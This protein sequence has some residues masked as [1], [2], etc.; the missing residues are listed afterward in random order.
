MKNVIHVHPWLI[1]VNVWQN[2]Y[3]IIKQNKLEIKIFLKCIQITNR[4]LTKEENL[5]IRKIFLMF[6]FTSTE[7]IDI[8]TR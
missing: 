6:T 2:Q 3:S 4:Q 1:H 7:E 5:V 8:K